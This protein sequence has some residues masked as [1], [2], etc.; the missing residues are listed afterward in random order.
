MKKIFLIFLAASLLLLCGC[1]VKY[2]NAAHQFS[3][4]FPETMTVLVPAQTKADDPVLKTF[5]ISYTYVE[6]RAEDGTQYLAVSQEGDVKKEVCVNVKEDESTVELW[7]LNKKDTELIGQFQTAMIDGL[8]ELGYVVKQKGEFQQGD[9]YCLYLNV[10]SGDNENFDTVYMATLY[11]GKQYSVLYRS[12]AALT[13]DD[14]DECHGIFDRFY[15]TETLP[16]PNEEPRDTTVLKAMLVVLIL[17]AVIFTVV[18]VIRWFALKKA[19]AEEETYVP[20]FADEFASS[21]KKEKK[22]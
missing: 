1:G 6:E 4:T 21:K 9:A 2:E 20:Q 12:T 5:D 16:N 14:I 19:P 11:N 8:T 3:I 13:Q 17:A 18:C 10:I 15:I 22:K 7:A